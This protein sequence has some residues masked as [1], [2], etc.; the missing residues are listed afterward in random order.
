[1]EKSSGHK[2]LINNA[3]YDNLQEDWYTAEDHPIALL[4][5][6]NKIRTPW[7]IGEIEKNIKKP[8]NVLDIG[9]GAGFLTNQLALQGHKVSGIDLSDPS[10]EIAKKHDSTG[11]VHY[12]H[13]NAY[14]LPFPDG[15]FDAVCAM[16]I[17]EHVEQPEMLIREASRVLRPGGY[18][19][20]HTFNRTLLS[21][22]VVI[23]GIDWF[24]KNAP[25]N[26]H[27]YELFITPM[28][29][30]QICQTRNL[31]V[32]RLVGLV[33]DVWSLAFWKL[34]FTRK[35]S[36]DFRFTFANTLSTG[37]CG[38]ATKENCKH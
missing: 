6:E 18:F 38:I 20:F 33:P 23:K 22:I 4:R 34:L 17:L 10:L 9:C 14:S 3:F 16:D 36:S 2:T 29:L 32:N 37:Y 30:K 24:V 26:I 5:A 15:S 28:E 8:A 7:V 12:V 21:Y 25:K 27:V 35:I 11:K 13:A 31:A 19:F 1:M